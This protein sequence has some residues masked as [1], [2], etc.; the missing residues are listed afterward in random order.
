MVDAPSDDAAERIEAF[1][2]GFRLLEAAGACEIIARQSNSAG[3]SSWWLG[4]AATARSYRVALLDAVNHG[5][6][7]IE[8]WAES[9]S[10]PT[11]VGWFAEERGRLSLEYEYWLIT[12]P[13]G[14]AYVAWLAT[15]VA[16]ADLD[17]ERA[18]EAL[19]RWGTIAGDFVDI[20]YI[21]LAPSIYEQLQGAADAL[22]RFLPLPQHPFS[23]MRRFALLPDLSPSKDR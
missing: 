18:V 10:G 12:V 13:G 2:A 9:C 3:S 1:L 5:Y 20:S 4:L 21:S 7:A 14:G 19:R 17:G 22:E 15:Y 16:A 8:Q 11:G 23:D 6:R